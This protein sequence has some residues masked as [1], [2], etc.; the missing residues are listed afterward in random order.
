M[1]IFASKFVRILF[2]LKFIPL[3][4]FN[5][6]LSSSSRVASWRMVGETGCEH[7][8]WIELIHR[9]HD[10]WYSFL[11][12]SDSK[13]I[14]ETVKLFKHF[15]RTP[16]TRYQSIWKCLPTHDSVTQHNKGG[17]TSIP[18]S[19]FEFTGHVF[20]WS[21]DCAATAIGKFSYLQV[22]IGEVRSKLVWWAK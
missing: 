3:R 4:I 10:L 14:S 11:S 2:H 1:F 21:L 12:Y 8:I 17:H 22:S 18:R 13:L 20:E 16:W 15:G 6:A 19:G 5:D 7:V 9:G